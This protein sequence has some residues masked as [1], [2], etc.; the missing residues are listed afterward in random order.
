MILKVLEA[1]IQ[2]LA[3]SQNSTT[4][5]AATA[6]GNIAID[7][8]HQILTCKL[9]AIEKLVKLLESTSECCLSSCR[10]ISRLAIPYENKSVYVK[11]ESLLE[12]LVQFCSS[13]NKHLLHFTAM[14]I[15]NLSSSDNAQGE[16]L[17]SKGVEALLLLMES[18]SDDVAKAA[19]K[20]L[21]N[22]GIKKKNHN[23]IVHSG[24]IMSLYMLLQHDNVKC[25]RLA[26]FAYRVIV[27]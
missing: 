24:G 19:T 13:Q 26:N 14:T 20:V 12:N 17:E 27:K 5:Y 7:S 11:N 1:L 6:I 16:I 22:L 18:C 8:F 4:S 23:R 15:C 10:A 9:G 3:L 21:C 25:V 2:L